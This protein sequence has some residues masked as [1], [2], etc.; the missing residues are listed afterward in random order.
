ML[1]NTLFQNCLIFL[2]TQEIR[3]QFVIVFLQFFILV[4]DI[5]QN[6][7]A[8]LDHLVHFL[9][10]LVEVIV[11]YFVSPDALDCKDHIF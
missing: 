11:H 4:Y 1:L 9:Y 7:D 8:S 10:E 6:I 2:E 3:K 5:E